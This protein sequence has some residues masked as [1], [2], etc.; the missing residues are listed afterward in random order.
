METLVEKQEKFLDAGFIVFEKWCRES[1]KTLQ[2]VENQNI[3]KTRLMLPIIDRN[4]EI[5]SGGFNVDVGC[6]DYS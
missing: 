6:I 3:V 1:H 5:L 2:F 4:A